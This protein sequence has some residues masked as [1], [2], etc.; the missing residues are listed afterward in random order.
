MTQAKNSEQ[1]ALWNGPGGQ[2]WVESQA[3]LERMLQPF[4]DM[5]V[6]ALAAD[7][8]GRVL[9]VGCGMGGTTIA[10]ARRLGGEVRCT[11]LDISAPMLAVSKVIVAGCRKGGGGT[12]GEGRMRRRWRDEGMGG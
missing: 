3:V 6:N 4:E 7:A 1:N 8:P 5:L 11:G 9:D 2:A 12:R 10:F